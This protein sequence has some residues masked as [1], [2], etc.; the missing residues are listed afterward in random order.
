MD[1]EKQDIIF[2]D[3]SFSKTGSITNWQ[4]NFNDG[5]GTINKSS[6]APFI[7]QFALSGTYK[8]SLI[9]T[10][11][12]GCNSSLFNQNVIVHPLP[13]PDFTISKTCLPNANALFTNK[14]SISDGSQN[15]LTY[16]WDFGDPNSGSNDSTFLK[17]P[18][19]LYTAIGPYTIKLSA[20]SSS[21][22]KKDTSL[23]YNDIHPQPSA[24]FMVSSFEGC[25]GTN[26]DFNDLSSGSDGMI[27]KWTW[28]FGDGSSS[29][30]QNPSHLFNKTGIFNVT[31]YVNDSNN[32]QSDTTSI[33]VT[34]DSYPT[35]NAKPDRFVL[36][37]DTIILSPQYSG[38]ELTFLWSPPDNLSSV[39]VP[40]PI[41]TGVTDMT[42]TITVTGKGNCTAS[43]KVFVKILRTPNVPNTFTPNNDGINDFWVIEDLQYYRNARVQVFDRNGRVVFESIGYPKPWDGNYKGTSSP[44]PIGTYYYIIEPGNGRKAVT[45]YVTVLK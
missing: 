2:S 6:G 11:N 37:G 35:V 34:I 9:V 41:L 45:G 19:H 22:C 38:S 29:T 14:S 40:N 4:W 17:D 20:T 8:V 33:N 36:E 23:I 24:S 27:N 44:V 12:N 16:T 15:L 1:C 42:Y 31:L 21:G 32:C 7:H 18:A 43:D 3:S 25:V 13:V 10:T 30:N 5:T 26:I 28:D 39:I